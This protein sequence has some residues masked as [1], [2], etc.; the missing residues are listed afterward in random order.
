MFY[1]KFSMEPI[2]LYRF[3]LS[4]NS[5]KKVEANLKK[6]KPEPTVNKRAKLN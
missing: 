4:P 1:R 5:N 3:K 2:C 6:V